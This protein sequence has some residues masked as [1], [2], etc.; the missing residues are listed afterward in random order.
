MVRLLHGISFSHFL[1]GEEKL[2]NL[3]SFP[4]VL[5]SLLSQIF[6]CMTCSREQVWLLH[7]P[8]ALCLFFLA[9]LSKN[10]LISNYLPSCYS[11]SSGKVPLKWMAI[12][13]STRVPD[14]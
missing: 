7:I 6:Q 3:M 4:L 8:R 5:A 1:V 13:I 12:L 2:I 9:P 14:I 11:K 10:I